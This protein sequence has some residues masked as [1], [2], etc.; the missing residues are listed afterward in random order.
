L[1]FC[2]IFAPRWCDFSGN[3]LLQGAFSLAAGNPEKPIQCVLCVNGLAR[4]PAGGS[5]EPGKSD[6][7]R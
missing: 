5:R 7:D 6:N 2:D 3:A 1:G 4:F